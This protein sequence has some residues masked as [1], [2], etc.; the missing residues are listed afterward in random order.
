M[1]KKIFLCISIALLLVLV[2]FMLIVY[3]G[4]NSVPTAGDVIIVLGCKLWGDQ[5]SPLLRY[6]LDMALEVYNQGLAPYIIVS[7]AQ[8]PDEDIAEALAMKRYL[9][10]RGIG[11]EKIFIEDNSFNTYQNLKHSKAIMDEMGFEKG[12]V[13]T[14]DFH[15]YRALVLSKKLNLSSSGAPAGGPPVKWLREKYILREVPALM[16]DLIVR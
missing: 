1:K 6:R 4:N 10:Q 2:P 9:V 3:Y 14:N 12:I 13:V 15:L 5:P 7:G 16:K 8:G 11:E